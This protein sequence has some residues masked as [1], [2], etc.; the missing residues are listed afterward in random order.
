MN[1]DGGFCASLYFFGVRVVICDWKGTFIHASR[2]R[3]LV[4]SVLVAECYTARLVLI[5]ANQ[6]GFR[7]VILEG[8]PLDVVSLLLDHS[9]VF[10][11][12]IC[13]TIHDYIDQTKLFT[14]FHLH[15]KDVLTWLLT[16]LLK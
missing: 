3:D 11:W 8:N 7:D 16:E 2:M 9:D 5:L 13:N 12:S 1:F 14:S 10:L 4:D 6:L 15:V